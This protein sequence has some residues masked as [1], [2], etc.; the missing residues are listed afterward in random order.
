M[1]E[2]NNVSSTTSSLGLQHELSKDKKC[3]H[4]LNHQK[5]M[6]VEVIE[7]VKKVALWVKKYNV[8]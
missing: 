6:F 3:N 5:H 1:R 2:K 7:L 4:T 8:D